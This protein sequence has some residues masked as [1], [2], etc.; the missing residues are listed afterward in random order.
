MKRAAGLLA[1]TIC[2]FGAA[3]A[4]RSGERLADKLRVF[5]RDWLTAYLNDES[6]WLMRFSTGKMD[7][8][9]APGVAFED[10]SR[11]VSAL[12]E[13]DLR[14]NE[15]KVRISG[16]ISL[17]TNDPDLNRSFGFL[18]TFNKI[19][20]K[21]H[22]IASSISPIPVVNAQPASAELL[23]LENEL[24]RAVLTGDS[25]AFDRL[26][27]PQ[28]VS[29]SSN[30][31]VEDR[32]GWIDVR[33]SQRVK[34]ADLRD[35]KVNLAGDNVAVITGILTSAGLNG[36]ENG[37]SRTERFTHTWAKTGGMWQCIAAHFTL[38]R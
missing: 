27:A 28:F 23:K 24:A 37:I 1:L 6:G 21:W 9:P 30:G 4:Q 17:L 20:G 36:D 15:M 16:T 2:M 7:V 29:T 14:A 31:H 11:A 32:G 33:K 19:D 34:S 13:T 8:A 18:D 10:R 25:L 12:M 5:E 38:V 22:V 35:M 26:L 3:A